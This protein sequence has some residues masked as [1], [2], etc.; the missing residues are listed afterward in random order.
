M[1]LFTTAAKLWKV[2]VL[3]YTDNSFIMGRVTAGAI[4]S[5]LLKNPVT[6]KSPKPAACAAWKPGGA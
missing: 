2:W 5:Y 6:S 4:N 1:S 3:V